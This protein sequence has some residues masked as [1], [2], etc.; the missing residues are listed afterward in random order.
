MSEGSAEGGIW[1]KIDVVSTA[2]QPPLNGCLSFLRQIMAN[3]KV[4][5]PFFQGFFAKRHE[6][7]VFSMFFRK[8]SLPRLGVAVCCQK[9][10]RWG[11]YGVLRHVSCFFIF[12]LPHMGTPAPPPT[13]LHLI[14]YL[15][16]Y[17]CILKTFLC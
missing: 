13:Y 14:I 8:K 3:L 1:G 17:N 9:D 16:Y 11:G 10:P 12:G 7:D 15:Y 2:A 6:I 4:N 5:Y